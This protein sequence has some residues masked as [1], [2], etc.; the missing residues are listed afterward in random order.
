MVTPPMANANELLM[1]IV[2]RRRECFMLKEGYI[3]SA[4]ATS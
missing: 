4:S 3:C 2:V 1:D